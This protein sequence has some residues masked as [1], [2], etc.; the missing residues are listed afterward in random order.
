MLE[1]VMALGDVEDAGTL[2]S[3][4]RNSNFQFA[5][6]KVILTDGKMNYKSKSVHFIHLAPDLV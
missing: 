4:G 5:N 6:D 1:V 3:G 2:V